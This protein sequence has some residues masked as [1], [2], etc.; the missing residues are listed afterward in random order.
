MIN[1]VMH[2]E[3]K[4]AYFTTYHGETADIGFRNMLTASGYNIETIDLREKE[5]PSDAGLVIISNPKQD[6]ERAAQGSTVRTEIERLRTFMDG[7]GN[8]FVALD[9]YVDKLHV[10]EEFIAEYGITVSQ[11]QT[12]SGL[13]KNIVRDSSNA[14]TADFFTL[15]ADYPDNEIANAIKA[16]VA[17]YN[18]ASVI[19]R[20]NA[21]LTLSGDYA[22]PLLISSPS[23]SVYAGADA[24]DNAGKYCV[25]AISSTG[26]TEGAGRI[27]VIP[28]VYLTATDTLIT[29]GYSNREFIFALIDELYGVDTLPYGC[30]AV[31]Y[32]EAQI[33]ENLT[34]GTA[35]IYTVA[36]M[37]VPAALAVVG[38]VIIKKRKNR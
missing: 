15:V 9:P 22:Q 14:I 12:E 1:W 24:I 21:A 16:T 36:I 11:T 5:I 23:S 29:G 10:L 17:K 31:D 13:L 6:F 3:H 37:A 27:F 18:S 26:S 20:E 2:D 8:L 7:G 28:G 32:T 33:L 4:T 34:M 35:R 30:K 38:A 25:A 19:V